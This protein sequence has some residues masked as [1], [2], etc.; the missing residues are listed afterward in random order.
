VTTNADENDAGATP[1]TPGGTGFSLREAITLANATAGA[2]TI[3]FKAGI[4]VAQTSPLPTLTQAATIIGGV[5]NASAVTAKKECIVING[6]SIVIDGLEIYGCRAR[7]IYIIG[8]SSNQ[9]TNCNVHDNDAGVETGTSS[10]TLTIGPNNVIRNSGGS[11]VLINVDSAQVIDNRIDTCAANGVFLASSANSRVIGNLI[12]RG[13]PGIGTSSGTT[14]ATIWHNT[15]ALSGAMGMTAGSMTL[16][17]VRNN[18][19]A[20][21]GTYAFTGA[22]GDFAFQDYNI[23]FGNPSG[24]CNGCTPG[25][26]TS[27][28]DPKFANVAG[29]DFTLLAGSPAINFGTILATDRNGAAPGNYNGTAPDAGYWESP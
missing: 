11:C 17:D 25:P 22:N 19:F 26:N 6:S 23:Y 27:Q 9:I 2:Q 15:I 24:V 16:G 14:N 12:L 13:N 21:N 10:G 4:V 5:V 28:L 18:I 20:L 7:P 8:G 1:A 29:G 3:G